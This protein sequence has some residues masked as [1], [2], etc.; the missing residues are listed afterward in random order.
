L[1]GL[2]T[3]DIRSVCGRRVV[4]AALL[5]IVGLVGAH[6]AR[7]AELPGER[8]LVDEDFS[9]GALPAGWVPALGDWRVVDGRLQATTTSARSRIAFGPSAPASFRLDATVRFV[10]VSDS[11]R[12]LNV[13]VDYHVADDFGAVLVARSATTAS[14]GLELAQAAAKGSSYSSSPVAR[15]P[16][17]IGTGQDHRL[18]LEVSGTHLVVSLDGVAAMTTDN[19]RRTGGGF[20]FV[21]NNSTVQFDDVLV[22][23][24]AAQPTPPTAPQNVQLRESGD[25]ASVTWAS[26]AQA[27]SAA[28]GTAATIA[29]YEVSIAGASVPESSVTWQPTIG[30]AHTFTGLLDNVEQAIRVRAIN[31][32][33][34]AGPAAVVRPVRGAPTVD[35]YKLGV[36]GGSWPS[37]HVQGIAVDEKK[38]FIYY[39]FT[40]LLVKTDLAGNIVG[41]VGG[42]TGHLGDLDFNPTDGRIYGSLEYKEAKAFYIAIFDVDK[43]DRVGMSAQNSPIV[44]AVYLPEVVKDFTADLD[45]NGVFDG[46]TANTPDHRYGDSGIDGV[47]FGPAFGSV[48]GRSYLTVAYGIYS[49]PSRIDNDNQVLLQYDPR[50]WAR[51]EHPLV[52]AAPHRDGP[53]QP[54]GKYFVFTGNTNFGVQNLEYDPWLERWF[55][56]VYT[57]SKPQYP[58]YS[59]FAVD[60]ASTPSLQAVRGLDGEQGMVLPLADDGLE[61]AATGIRGWRQKADV[62]IQSLGHGLFYLSVDGTQGG[63]QTST[64]TLQAWTGN[65]NDPFT[66]VTAG[67]R[68]APVFTSGAPADATAK[69]PYTHTFTARG[70]PDPAFRIGG[71]ELPPGLS[72]DSTTGVLSGTPAAAGRYAF[73]VVASNGQDD[74][75]QDI[76]LEIAP[77][78]SVTTTGTVGASVPATLS[79]TLGAATPTFGA[80]TPGITKHYSTTTMATVISTAGDAALSVSDPGHLTNGSFSLPSPL[81]V[82]F[83][84]AAWT[85][86]VSNDVVTV[87]FKQH[88]GSTDALRTGAYSKTLTYTL[89]TTSP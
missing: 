76:V 89:S 44:S 51:F 71:G 79:L 69:Q 48:A 84:K 64:L 42:F 30:L 57:G 28:D 13:G 55:M 85:A 63:N 49:N 41:T 83:S 70:F 11:A 8:V 60:A 72:L 25:T 73:T 27:G 32:N 22:T 39:S 66:P 15:G 20:G 4:V 77:P 45:G 52:E 47:A 54:D 17:N 78:S 2:F 10:A 21:I 65:P 67:Y 74:A 43:V 31:S 23:E 61:D 34:A 29:R 56:G 38:G 19:L 16:V 37:G 46:D 3:L 24:T 26:P 53:A 35:G 7:A 88:I 80:F 18:T 14:N 12:W 59:L 40:N 6:P 9:G 5:A 75:G 58:N 87:T 68:V 36:S 81:E 62:G 33:G 86:P 82:L 50:D 1:E